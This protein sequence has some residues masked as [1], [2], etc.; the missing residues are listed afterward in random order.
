MFLAR[1]LRDPSQ[2]DTHIRY[3]LV[4]TVLKI[5]FGIEAED[6]NK[7]TLSVNSALEGIHEG[8]IPGKW[9]IEMLPILR[10]I[11]AWMPGAGW[12]QKFKE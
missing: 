2:L 8:L 11:P 3:T 1:L 9:L 12:E 7:Y 5:M 6:N 4:R 10:H